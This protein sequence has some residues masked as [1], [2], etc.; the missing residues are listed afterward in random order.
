MLRKEKASLFDI[1]AAASL[2]EIRPR[3]NRFNESFLSSLAVGW[4]QFNV[5]DTSKL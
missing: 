3:E 2:F 4:N 5:H 1:V